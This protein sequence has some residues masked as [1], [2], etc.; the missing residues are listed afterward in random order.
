MSCLPDFGSMQSGVLCKIH[1]VDTQTMLTGCS[2]SGGSNLYTY[3][4]HNSDEQKWYINLIDD[5]YVIR[6]VYT[7]NYAALDSAHYG[8]EVVHPFKMIK[9]PSS[10][11]LP[12]IYTRIL[13][14]NTQRGLGALTETKKIGV[15]ATVGG[16]SKDHQLWKLE[17]LPESSTSTSTITSALDQKFADINKRIDQ[18][19]TD[20]NKRIDQVMKSVEEMNT[21]M[22][23][24]EKMMARSVTG[25]AKPD[26]NNNGVQ[27]QSSD[28]NNEAP[29]GQP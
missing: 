11:P 25:E 6:N 5:G 26:H 10:E 14:S 18:K 22:K 20:M 3:S 27:N 12:R 1:N 13:A 4:D 28:Q 16:H 9:T 2:K 21:M 7:G 24:F 15:S 8:T 17:R 23:K 29:N 19:F